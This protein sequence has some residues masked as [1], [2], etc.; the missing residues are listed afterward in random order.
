MQ[1][2]AAQLQRRLVFAGAAAATTWYVGRHFDRQRRPL[3]G[4]QASTTADALTSL[5][6]SGVSVM[7]SVVDEDLVSAVRA[8]EVYQGMP[9][10]QP[11]RSSQKPSKEWR[12]SSLGR[13]HRREEAM[14]ESDV[15]VLERVEERIR[16]LVE[17]FF[18]EDGE[19]VT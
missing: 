9:T 4:C 5:R 15:K 2:R 11:Q 16:P 6:R 8:T 19:H 1:S 18:A 13:Y 14:C 12:L 17:G 10:A 7:S 3:R